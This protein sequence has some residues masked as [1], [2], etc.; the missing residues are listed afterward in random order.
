MLLATCLKQIDIIRE[1]SLSIK[2]LNHL[3]NYQEVGC[4]EEKD[5]LNDLLSKIN[6]N[7]IRDLKCKL[8][9]C[10]VE[11]KA[12]EDELLNHAC[13]SIQMFF[14]KSIKFYFRQDML[15]LD[16]IRQYKAYLTFLKEDLIDVHL[17]IL[18]SSDD[19]I[20]FKK[21]QLMT[22]IK[23]LDKSLIIRKDLVRSYKA[24]VRTLM[25]L[26]K[27]SHL[28]ITEISNEMTLPDIMKIQ[29]H[30]K[31]L[32]EYPDYQILLDDFIKNAKII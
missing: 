24:E 19:L 9:S 32:K 8:S 4:I 1:T 16:T 15:S 18:L 20:S 11:I 21:E 23:E 29:S 25:S 5:N 27:N 6:N 12:I 14:R 28:Y 13:I 22:H 3:I 30:I 10:K 2:R 7:H 17:N 26:N 31:S